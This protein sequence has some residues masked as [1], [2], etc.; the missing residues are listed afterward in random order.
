MKIIC[1]E[2]SAAFPDHTT[3]HSFEWA[4]VPMEKAE[5]MS[6]YLFQNCSRRETTWC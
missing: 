3:A 5:K 4:F 1:L 6:L 2:F